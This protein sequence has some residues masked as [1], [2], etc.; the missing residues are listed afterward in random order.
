MREY[1]VAVI[2][3]GPAGLSAAE[4]AAKAGLRVAVIDENK[5]AGGQLVKQ[6]HKFFGISANQAGLRGYDIA[7]SLIREATEAG[8]QIW[9]NT[10]VY[11]VYPDKTIVYGP[12]K[13]SVVQ[14]QP[15]A[16]VLAA[17]ASEDGVFFE[18]NDMPGIMTAGAAQDMV[19]IKRVLPGRKAVI[20]G[21]G[22]VGLIVA[23]QL[24][25]A[26]M[27]VACVVEQSLEIKGYGVYASRLRREGVPIYTGARIVR[28]T[29]EG[30]V[31]SVEIAGVGAEGRARL[32]VG[33]DTVCIAAGLSPMTELS[34]TAGCRQMYVPELGG[35]VPVHDD[36]MR[37][38]ES[39]IYVAGDMAGI[40][41]A[42]IAMEE[43]RLAGISCAEE[44]GYYTRS[45]ADHKR[46]QVRER[47]KVQRAGQ[48]YA[49]KRRAKE[50]QMSALAEVANE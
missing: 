43:G 8:A 46:Q 3:A 12:G 44:L 17:G 4:E 20:V 47:L 25:Q 19:N 29:G 34:C 14:M 35:N 11:A 23:Y 37:T 45:E 39:G 31:S 48:Y 9:T 38:T 24:T 30:S 13:K 1:D 5:E 49:A 40:E 2:G 32:T 33:A 15:K 18:N 36:N 41:E 27:E 28:C 42:G 10:P 7:L 22:N 50:I 26:G 21:S 6:I 16:I